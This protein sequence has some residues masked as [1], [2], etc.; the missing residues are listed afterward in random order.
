MIYKPIKQEDID[1]KIS[2]A[3]KKQKVDGKPTKPASFKKVKENDDPDEES[4]DGNSTS[5]EKSFDESS[6]EE[7]SDESSEDSD[8][9]ASNNEKQNKKQKEL[10]KLVKKNFLNKKHELKTKHKVVET[11]TGIL[12]NKPSAHPL[13][14]HRVWWEY[15]RS[16]KHKKRLRRFLI[17]EGWK[18]HSSLDIMATTTSSNIIPLAPLK[19]EIFWTPIYIR[20]LK[21]LADKEKHTLEARCHALYYMM[22]CLDWYHMKRAMGSNDAIIQETILE[23]LETQRKSTIFAH[24]K[25][26]ME[27]E[28]E[29]TEWGKA[30]FNNSRFDRHA[31]KAYENELGCIAPDKYKVLKSEKDKQILKALKNSVTTAKKESKKENTKPKG[32]SKAPELDECFDEKWHVPKDQDGGIDFC[33]FYQSE[34]CTRRNSCK[35]KHRCRV[36]GGAHPANKCDKK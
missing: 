15:M 36:C 1:I 20:I 8:N 32:K 3:S 22:K 2:K 19:F 30:N 18:L 35:Y 23:A 31:P 27:S 6:A 34:S 5:E 25:A 33:K 26:L 12:I 28:Q 29:V 21:K 7:S 4:S 17:R 10:K 13:N 11:G 14:A 24:Y 9:N 16:M